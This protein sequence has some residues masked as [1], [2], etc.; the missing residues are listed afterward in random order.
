M[1]DAIR[2]QFAIAAI[3]LTPTVALCIDA[4]DLRINPVSEL[5]EVVDAAWSGSNYNVRYTQ[6][7]PDGEQRA[8]TLLTTNTANDNDPRI[9]STPTGDAIVVWWRDAKVD[10][11]IYRKRKLDSGVWGPERVVGRT[12]ESGSHPRIVLSNGVPW[13]AYQ[14]QNSKTRS[15]GA[16]IIDSDPEPFL[17]VIIGTTTFTGDLDIQIESELDHLWV[18]WIDNATSVGFSEY[19]SQTGLWSLPRYESFA[20]ETVTAARERIRENVLDIAGR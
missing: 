3:V 7:T 20:G 17:R 12:T 15:I 16:S 10:A 8:S 5:V 2:R 6:V 1:H 11:V 13:V 9:D 14:I 18:T 19:D 4:P